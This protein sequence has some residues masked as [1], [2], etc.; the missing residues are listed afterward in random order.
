MLRT[1]G[2]VSRCDWGFSR[3][4]NGYGVVRPGGKCHNTA[5]VTRQE[6]T[7]CSQSGQ[8]SRDIML[9]SGHGCVGRVVLIRLEDVLQT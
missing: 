3:A 6:L 5:D 9:G 4:G 8:Y 7:D 1:A 2:V